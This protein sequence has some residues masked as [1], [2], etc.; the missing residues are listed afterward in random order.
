MQD[1]VHFRTEHLFIK[2]QVTFKSRI[3]TQIQL[4]SKDDKYYLSMHQLQLKIM[5]ELK[6]IIQQS[7]QSP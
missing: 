3:T 1:C 5:M 2:W 4:L 7:T 6:S